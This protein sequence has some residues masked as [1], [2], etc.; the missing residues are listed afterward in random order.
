MKHWGAVGRRCVIALSEPHGQAV[1]QGRCSVLEAAGALA[2][3]RA[4]AD[5]PPSLDIRERAR[6]ALHN[7]G[8]PAPHPP[9]ADPRRGSHGGP[10]GGSEAEARALRAANA[11]VAGRPVQGAP[12]MFALEDSGGGDDGGDDGDGGGGGDDVLLPGL[13][14]EVVMGE[15]DEDVVLSSL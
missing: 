12:W 7:F 13:E 1:A 11:A 10:R 4:L 15:E 3:L 5:D 14:Q 8:S 6:T 2:A 9:P